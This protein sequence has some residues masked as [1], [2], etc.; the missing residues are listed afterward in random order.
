MERCIYSIQ[1]ILLY[2]YTVSLFTRGVRWGTAWVPIS[3]P[4]CI[5]CVSCVYLYYISMECVINVCIYFVI[6]IVPHIKV[7]SRSFL[8]RR[9][10][11]RTCQKE[12]TLVCDKDKKIYKRST[13]WCQIN[14]NFCIL[15]FKKTESYARAL[16]CQCISCVSG[17]EN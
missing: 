4:N 7:F 6:D 8:L 5:Q 1:Y 16:T 2:M 17:E 14:A 3:S 12:H 15:I 11:S 9:H 13:A 10:H